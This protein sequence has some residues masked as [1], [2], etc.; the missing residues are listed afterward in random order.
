MLSRL[1]VVAAALAGCVILYGFG[2][3]RIL[4]DENE[5]RRA[6]SRLL[7]VLVTLTVFSL[8]GVVSIELTAMFQRTEIVLAWP[9]IVAVAAI[10]FGL[11]SAAVAAAVL[12]GRDPF[13]LS[14]TGRTV[15]VYAAEAFLGLLCIHIRLTMP[16]LF[17]GFFARWWPL[18]VMAIAFVGVG[19]S[20]FLRGGECGYWRHRWRTLLHCCPCCRRSDS[21]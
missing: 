8:V 20:E 13:G 1:I 19:L 11:A 21:G 16:W 10:L 3:A 4:S 7:P 2:P 15:Y 12:P 5:S 17:H 18:V 14:E 6:A 9:G